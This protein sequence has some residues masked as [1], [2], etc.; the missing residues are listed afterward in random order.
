MN[1][2]RDMPCTVDQLGRAYSDYSKVWSPVYT[3]GS[4]LI[5]DIY[6]EFQRVEGAP[7]KKS[8][9]DDLTIVLDLHDPKGWR[10]Q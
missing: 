10:V 6:V 7:L 9:P 8:D 5:D 1:S 4:I 2:I 3:E